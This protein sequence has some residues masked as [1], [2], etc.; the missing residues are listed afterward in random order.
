MDYEKISFFN[1]SSHVLINTFVFND[2]QCP[3]M[4]YGVEMLVK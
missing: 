4:I 3:M 1:E 2:V